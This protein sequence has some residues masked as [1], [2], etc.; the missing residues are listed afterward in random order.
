MIVD[1]QKTQT[2]RW[3]DVTP[4]LIDRCNKRFAQKIEKN[5][6]SR[7]PVFSLALQTNLAAVEIEESFRNGQA[8]TQ[9]PE[10]SR[11]RTFAL[12]ESFED[13]TLPLRFDANASIADFEYE[14][15]I[16]I[17]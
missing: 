16:L 17:R 9:S 2:S 6:K 3:C 1:Q 5:A 10:L 13:A 11:N 15:T 4:G 14:L 7:A 8:Q 12:V